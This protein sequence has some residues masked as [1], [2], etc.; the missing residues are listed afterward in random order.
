MSELLKATLLQA[1]PSSVVWPVNSKK[2]AHD[3]D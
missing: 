3:A 1:T 2:G